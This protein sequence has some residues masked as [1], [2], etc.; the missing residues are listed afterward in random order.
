VI[1]SHQVKNGGVQIVDFDGVFGHAI[2]DIVCAAN[3]HSGLDAAAR[4]FRVG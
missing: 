2:A 1:D 4:R 3:R